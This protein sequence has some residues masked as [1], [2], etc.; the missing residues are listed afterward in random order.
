MPKLVEFKDVGLKAHGRL[1]FERACLR[2]SGHEKVLLTAPVASGKADFVRL[3]AGLELPDSGVIE[4]LGVDLSKA[5]QA[6]LSNVRGRMGFIFEENILI[7]NLKVVENVA[8]PLLYHSGL[9]YGELMEKAEGLLERSGFKGDLWALPGPLPLYA[10]KEV[11]V[12]RALA[13][14]PKIIVCESMGHGLTDS[15]KRS[16]AGLLLDYYESSG[17]AL[18]I[19]TADSMEDAGLI[20]PDRVVRIEG[21]GFK[22]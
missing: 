20:R 7:S 9:G 10:K 1:V 13:L 19:F 5:S 15:E 21:M 16:I 18:L 2:L 3:L 6:D 22:E 14:Q 8:L 4:V 11:A 17:D 12:A